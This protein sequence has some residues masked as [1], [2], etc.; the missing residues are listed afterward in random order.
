QTL[1]AARALGDCLIVVLNSDASVRRLKGPAR[2][3]T[4]ER[5][6]AA[7]LEAL[8]CVDA[9]LVFGEDTPAAALER[10][11]PDVWVKGG[12]YAGRRLPEADALEAWGGR[13]VVVPTLEGHST[14]RLIEETITR[15]AS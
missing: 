7:V 5:D 11:R 9:V 15:A 13:A 12:D 6:R 1:Q 2:P 8:E 10:L 4:G 3:V 14:T